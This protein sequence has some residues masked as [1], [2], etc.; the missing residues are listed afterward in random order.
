MVRRRIRPA[1]SM[2][3]SAYRLRS[4]LVMVRRT[5]SSGSHGVDSAVAHPGKRRLERHARLRAW[6]DVRDAPGCPRLAGVG[7]PQLPP[8]LLWP[9]RLTK[10]NLAAAHRAVVA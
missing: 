3:F 5:C 6:K 8:V 9:G 4:V 7:V 10:R 2:G 1:Q